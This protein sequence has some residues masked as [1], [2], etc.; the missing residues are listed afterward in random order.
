M[1]SL[2][3]GGQG[4]V[5]QL[6]T[7]SLPDKGLH[8]PSRIRRYVCGGVTQGSLWAKALTDVVSGQGC[9]TVTSNSN[10]G[11]ELSNQGSAQG[12]YTTRCPEDGQGENTKIEQPRE[13]TA[14]HRP[15][16]DAR[17]QRSRSSE[18]KGTQPSQ[19]TKATSQNT[20]HTSSDVSGK[21]SRQLTRKNCWQSD[22]STYAK[23]VVNNCKDNQGHYNGLIR[24]IS[25]PMFL[26]HCYES[27][28]GK[29]GNMTP[30]SDGQT[31][32]GLDWNWFVQ[33]A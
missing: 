17:A 1:V 2:S 32:D 11:T 9:R 27:I 14:S 30:G 7:H 6:D 24:I 21:S 25:D 10:I 4:Q 3:W 31:L 33:L 28:K 20:I 16:D 18:G 13:V 29:T 26:V 5:N 23:K 8:I 22:A 12:P 15:T 19:A